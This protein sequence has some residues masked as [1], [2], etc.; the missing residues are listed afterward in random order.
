[1]ALESTKFECIRIQAIEFKVVDTG[2]HVVL[3]LCSNVQRT[4]KRH[5]IILIAA[6][7]L[8]L[9]TVTYTHSL[10]SGMAPKQHAIWSLSNI[11]VEDCQPHPQAET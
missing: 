1:M 11:K 2:K 4:V 3:K 10:S 9:G 8:F 7:S 5:Q 6:D